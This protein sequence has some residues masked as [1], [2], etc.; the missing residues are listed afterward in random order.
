[1]QKRKVLFFVVII[2]VALNS[3]CF[4][5]VSTI[6]KNTVINSKDTVYETIKTNLVSENIIKN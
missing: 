6:F 4:F 2:I 5:I 1:M 3:V